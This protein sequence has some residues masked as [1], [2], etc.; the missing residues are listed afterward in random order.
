M[1]KLRAERR[2][3]FNSSRP[4]PPFFPPC[5]PMSLEFLLVVEDTVALFIYFP[6][7]YLERLLFNAF[8]QHTQV[9]PLLEKAKKALKA[10]LLNL[11]INSCDI[12]ITNTSL[13]DLSEK[14]FQFKEDVRQGKLG[15]TSQ[16]WMMYMDSVWNVLHCLRA[17]KMNYFDLHITSLENM[18]PLF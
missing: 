13:Q 8:Q 12:S 14:Y 3:A 7:L 6:L 4:V 10:V 15:K 1:S 18:C 16:Y 2:F 11:N 5:I 17:T 9:D